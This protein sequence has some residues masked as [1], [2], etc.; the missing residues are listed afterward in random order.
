MYRKKKSH[1]PKSLVLQ[2][3][4][5][6]KTR[7]F[8]RP[9]GAACSSVFVFPAAGHRAASSAARSGEAL[10]KGRHREWTEAR[11]AAGLSRRGGKREQR[12]YSG[13]RTRRAV[14][15]A[16][17]VGVRR[18]RSAMV[19]GRPTATARHAQKAAARERRSSRASGRR[20]RKRSK[21]ERT[22]GRRADG[23][24][25]APLHQDG[26]SDEEDGEWCVLFFSLFGR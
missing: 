11:N 26:A 23:P 7:R 2:Q 16:P 14:S 24:R 5:Q 17:T 4:T 25:E 20:R 22:R 9:S 1:G 10:R 21:R 13:G 8:L 12:R 18:R 6:N 15:S 19:A 3:R